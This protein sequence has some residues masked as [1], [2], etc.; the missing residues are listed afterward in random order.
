MTQANLLRCL[1]WFLS[2][3]SGA[4]PTHSLSKALIVITILELKG[5]TAPA[6]M[7]SSVHQVSTLPS[8]LPISDIPAANT[9][10]GHPFF[11]VALSLKH[12]K[13]DLSPGSTPEDLSDNRA[14]TGT[15]EGSISSGYSTPPIQPV[16]SHNPEQLEP[17]LFK[18]ATNPD[19]RLAADALGSTVD[20]DRDSVVEVSRDDSDQ[21]DDESDLSSDSEESAA[22]SAA[23]WPARIAFM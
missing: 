20:H 16:A 23:G 1:P 17:E 2:V 7:S 13:Q 10:V 12:K 3:M 19:E 9:P 22:D 21:S 8:V 6:S 11:T 5:T 15:E 14:H 18:A 4:G